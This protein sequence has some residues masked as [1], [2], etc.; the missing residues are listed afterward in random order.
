MQESK[1]LE[2]EKKKYEE[3]ISRMKEAAANTLV[4][5]KGAKLDWLKIAAEAVSRCGI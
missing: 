3:D 5:P 2:R 1:T 4:P